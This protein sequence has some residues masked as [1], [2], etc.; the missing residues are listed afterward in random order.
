MSKSFN[1]AKGRALAVEILIN[2]VLPWLLYRYSVAHYGESGA[3]ILSALPPLAWSGVEL[4]RFRRVDALSLMVL[5][6]I[7]LS[8]GALLLG[9]SPRMLLMRESLI[10]GLVGAAFLLSL[11]LDKPLIF[12]LAR[13]TVARE[14]RQAAQGNP[15]GAA[16]AAA[17]HP[18]ATPDRLDTLWRDQPD[19][20][21]SMRLMSLVWGLGLVGETALRAWLA[22][23]WPV[24]RFLLISPILSYAIF[25]AL[26]GWTVWYR[27]RMRRRGAVSRSIAAS[28]PLPTSQLP[29]QSPPD[30]AQS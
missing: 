5:A 8:L 21:R 16:S 28:T 12:H 2:F 26:I 18:A 15:A 9:G 30:S 10:S 3:L 22:W 27:I 7:V 25:G 11:A 20:V 14:A 24:E 19:F 17:G 29:P 6:G 1:A 4:L 13:A 23:T